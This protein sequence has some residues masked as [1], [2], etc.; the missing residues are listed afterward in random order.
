MGFDEDLKRRGVEDAL[1]FCVDGLTGSKKMSRSIHHQLHRIVHM[2]F[3]QLHKICQRQ[4][5]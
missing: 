4:R 3:S 1:F 2:A 5:Y